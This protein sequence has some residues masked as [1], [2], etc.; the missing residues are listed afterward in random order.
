[1]LFFVCCDDE[2]CHDACC[3]SMPQ[4]IRIATIKVAGVPEI[5]NA[6]EKKLT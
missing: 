3:Y 4:V 5:V 2:R 1:V 6:A